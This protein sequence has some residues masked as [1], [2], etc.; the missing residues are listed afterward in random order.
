MVVAPHPDD[1]T[2]GCGGTAAIMLKCGIHVD[3]VFVSDGTLSHPGSI[4]YPAA[5][6]RALREQEALR[7]VKILGGNEDDTTFCAFPD[8]NVPARESIYFEAAVRYLY[9]I[10]TIKKPKTIFIPWENDPHPDHRATFQIVTAAVSSLTTRPSLMQYPVWFWEMG[11][12]EDVAMI[13][14]MQ[15][16]AVDISATLPV[17]LAALKAHE[18]QVTNLIDDDPRG[19]RLSDRMI[20]HFNHGREIFFQNLHDQ[21]NE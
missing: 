17:K 11:N 20:A 5:R 14:K 10:L 12:Q 18:S 4:K 15:V 16:C 2:L 3:F 13:G 19:F 7:A 1:E 21:V 9:S 8:R 6:L